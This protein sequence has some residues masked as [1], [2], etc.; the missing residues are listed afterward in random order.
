MICVYCGSSLA[1]TN[2][3]PQ[4]RSNRVWRRRTCVGCQVAYTTEEQLDLGKAVTIN[5]RPF[6]R[7]K[8]FL[9]LYG[10]CRHRSTAI[11]DAGALTDTVTKR[12]LPAIV[13][14]RLDR[15]TM[16]AVATEVL[17]RFDTAAAVQY[18]AFHR[19]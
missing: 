13:G 18:R 19:P 6:S 1:V 17:R 15:G 7:D 3:R 16:V 2:S 4:H 10:A 12:L 9:S 5:G 8:L 14:G 11:K